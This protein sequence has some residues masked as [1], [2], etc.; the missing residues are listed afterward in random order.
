VQIAKERNVNMP[1]TDNGSADDHM[2]WQC[3]TDMATLQ[4][5]M[6]LKK[7]KKTVHCSQTAMLNDE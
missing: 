3:I 2:L 5:D 6:P 4:E 7:K 1:S